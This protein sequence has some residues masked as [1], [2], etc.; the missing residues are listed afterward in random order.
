MKAI[1][2]KF[3]IREYKE[4]DIWNE[5]IYWNKT[6]YIPIIEIKNSFNDL[7]KKIN[8]NPKDYGIKEGFIHQLY[9]LRVKNEQRYSFECGIDLTP[10]GN[11]W[12]GL[13]NYR[14]KEFKDYKS[15]ELFFDKKFPNGWDI[16]EEE[17]FT[18][19]Y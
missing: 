12:I 15:M 13:D 14:G 4:K 2:D 16:I 3:I 9:Q 11:F 19:E 17:Y 1:T 10:E 8:Y 18:R 5:D 7:I 6:D